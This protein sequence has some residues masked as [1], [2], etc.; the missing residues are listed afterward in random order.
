M[1]NTKPYLHASHHL[2]G[3]SKICSDLDC[4]QVTIGRICAD[5]WATHSP[6]PV[7]KPEPNG[8]I[9]R[10]W[11]ANS[12]SGW[13]DQTGCRRP[14]RAGIGGR[15]LS[16]P[17]GGDVGTSRPITR[18]T[19]ASGSSQWRFVSGPIPGCSSGGGAAACVRQGARAVASPIPNVLTLLV[20]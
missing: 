10:I 15:G 9:V 16:L 6:S 4:L 1:T 8:L 20:R 12:A 14:H 11:R 13:S 19:P 3:R 7:P 5:G 17:G 18:Q 2:L